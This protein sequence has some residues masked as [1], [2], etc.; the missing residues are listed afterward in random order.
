MFRYSTFFYLFLVK[1]KGTK[2]KLNVALAVCTFDSVDN[3]NQSIL[4]F[5]ISS[6]FEI[7]LAI[8]T[9]IS[10]LELYFLAMLRYY[11]NFAE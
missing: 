10:T 7:K 6:H 1:N 9:E 8:L 5:Y 11:F 3:E 4:L 2:E